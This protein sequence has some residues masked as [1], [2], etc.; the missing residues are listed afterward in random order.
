MLYIRVVAVQHG[1]Y[2]KREG[3]LLLTA[4]TEANGGSV[5]TFEMSP[6]LV[7]SLACRARKRDFCPALPTLV[8]PE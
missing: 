7:G 1:V 4:E 6:S 5:S 8:G 2:T 3:W